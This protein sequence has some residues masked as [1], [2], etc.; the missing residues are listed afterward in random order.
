MNCTLALAAP[1]FLFGIFS[2]DPAVIEY[3]VVF[4]RVAVCTFILAVPHGAFGAVI[5]GSGN[6]MLSLMIGLLD[7][8]LL[9]LVISITFSEALEM[10]VVGYF[11]GNSLPRIAPAVIGAVYFFSGKWK[12]RKLLTEK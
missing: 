12:T 4:M 6:A 1:E 8:I 5:T 11:Y 3:G 10:G 2:K 9:R 7:G